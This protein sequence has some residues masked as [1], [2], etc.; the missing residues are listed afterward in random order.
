MG[1]ITPHRGIRPGEQVTLYRTTTPLAADA[2]FNTPLHGEADDWISSEMVDTVFIETIADQASASAGL[3]FEETTDPDSDGAEQTRWT[4]TLV[5]DTPKTHSIQP[6]LP[7][8]KVTLR[9]GGTIQ[10]AL[11]HKVSIVA[12]S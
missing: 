6:E 2:E 3:K 1:K 11:R 8:W 9:N 4:A 5:A 10:G 12:P 7:W